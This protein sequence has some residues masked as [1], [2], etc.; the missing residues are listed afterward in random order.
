M[1]TQQSRIMRIKKRGS[2]T[3]LPQY[4]E[5]VGKRLDYIDQLRNKIASDTTEVQLISQDSFNLLSEHLT[6]IKF[7]ENGDNKLLLFYENGVPMDIDGISP[8][9]INYFGSSNRS[10]FD[11]SAN[12]KD[13]YTYRLFLIISK[14]IKLGLITLRTNSFVVKITGS[15][16][17]SIET[18]YFDYGNED[19][20]SSNPHD[21]GYNCWGSWGNEIRG[22]LQQGELE[23]SIRLITGRMKQININDVGK[24]INHMK[25]I[26]KYNYPNGLK[27][28]GLDLLASLFIS[29]GFSFYFTE[30][31]S[32]NLEKQV[33]KD[34]YPYGFD[35]I[36][37]TVGDIL[38]LFGVSTGFTLNQIKNKIIEI[39]EINGEPIIDNPDMD[40]EYALL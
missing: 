1:E 7:S 34:Y 35:G 39:H 22:L 37:Y 11:R 13:S 27:F 19:E 4:Q 18:E 40:Q 16:W 23:E 20:L 24:D 31:T 5:E 33:V 9:H 12:L 36:L 32:N 17:R 38:Y 2:V 28:I 15:D 21:N 10:I 29:K 6:D 30:L 26:I 14:M 8:S 25:K 3:E